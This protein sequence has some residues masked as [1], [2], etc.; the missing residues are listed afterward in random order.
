M[1]TLPDSWLSTFPP[2]AFGADI[3]KFLT[4]L[5][6]GTGFQNLWMLRLSCDLGE[7]KQKHAF[8]NTFNTGEIYY[9]CTSVAHLV[10][11]LKKW[12]GGREEE[13]EAWL[14]RAASTG[15]RK[16]ELSTQNFAFIIVLQQQPEVS[17]E[18]GIPTGA[19]TIK[20]HEKD[21]IHLT[22]I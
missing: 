9:V 1:R 13:E 14:C 7:R 20:I 12:L 6:L 5:V 8:W 21:V 10:K 16:V 17:T 22:H 15:C 11:P 4:S 2:H 19:G 3:N 18:T